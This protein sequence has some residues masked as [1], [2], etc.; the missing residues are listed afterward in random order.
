MRSNFTA[1]LLS[2]ICG[3]LAVGLYLLVDSYSRVTMA[4]AENTE[5]L[6]QLNQQF[7]HAPLTSAARS[8]ADSTADQ[9]GVPFANAEFFPRDGQR[10]YTRV[11][12][13]ASFSGNFNQLIRSEQTTGAVWDLCNDSLAERNLARP[14]EWEPKLA[15]SWR[16]SDDGLV[17]TIKLRR[18]AK[19]HP[20]TDP[21]TKEKIPAK[22]VTADDFVFFWE[23]L[24]N[25][26]IPCDSLRNY[27]EM[28]KSLTALD[29]HT[30]RVEWREP[31][32]LSTVF[33]LGLSPL[34]RHYFRPDPQ[35]TDAEFADYLKSTPRNMWVVGCGAYRFAEYKPNDS[36][37]FELFPDYYG[38]KPFAEKIVWRVIPEPSIQLVELQKGS[39]SDLGL[40]PEQWTKE[41]P[42]PKF[43]VITPDLLTAAA[44]AAAWEQVKA[45]GGAPRNG[46]PRD[47]AFEKYQYELPAT[48]WS[49]IGWNLKNPLFADRRT[50]RALAMLIDRDRILREV[51][52]GFGRLCDGPFVQNSPYADPEMPAVPYDPP[53]AKELLAAAGWTDSDGDGFLDK[54]IDGKKRNFAFTMI[55][56]STNTLR[57]QIAT[58]MQAE[59]K[60]AGIDMQVNA[61]DWSVVVQKLEEKSFDACVMGWTGVLEPDP[62]QVWHGSQAALS[63][64]SNHVSFVNADADR[65]MAAGRR[66]I[67]PVKRVAIYREFYRLVAA[68]QPYMFLLSNVALIAQKKEIRNAL[69]YR[70]GMAEAFQ[71]AP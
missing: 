31:Y 7:R 66:E 37:T 61:L 54:I 34:P 2:L 56:N 24:Q 65:L 9:T 49:Y 69:I 70:L 41:T 48:S 29:D 62:Y 50:R 13:V 23:C 67:D 5:A 39:L 35:M 1:V 17:F 18:N 25:P 4:I 58:I 16:V 22:P 46:E 15:E 20:Y 32:A 45:S 53:T 3:L 21:L 36:L 64:S 71:W 26:L 43:R 11:S 19:W 40:M 44:D 30:L 14:L 38:L 60:N 68:E 51:Y 52:Q 27:Y 10:G 42:A 55:Y 59:L 33:T 47:Y 63:G 57:R 12:A 6:R 8:S 28:V